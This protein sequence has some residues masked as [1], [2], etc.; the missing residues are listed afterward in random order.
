MAELGRADIAQQYRNNVIVWENLHCVVRSVNDDCTV[1]LRVISDGA[2]IS[3]VPFSLKTFKPPSFRLGMC[4]LDGLTAY[5]TRIPVRKMGIG[6]SSENINVALVGDTGRYFSDVI[7]LFNG[8]WLVNTFLG[9][10]PSISEALSLAKKYNGVVAFDRQMA[11]SYKGEVYYKTKKVGKY[12][13]SVPA[14][15][16]SFTAKFSYLNK[17]LDLKY[18]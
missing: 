13:T 10:Y 5:I 17:I 11:V 2:L 6:L 14:P 8:N 18:D 3:R 15:F 1:N 12:V 16:V 9:N 4:T 7:H